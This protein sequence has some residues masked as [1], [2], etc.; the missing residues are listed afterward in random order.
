MG[1]CSTCYGNSDPNE[2]DTT[3]K[4]TSKLKAETGFPGAQK[5]YGGIQSLCPKFIRRRKLL[6]WVSQQ[7]GSLCQWRPRDQ[8]RRIQ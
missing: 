8:Q 5:G 2:V 6:R 3:Q 1:N 4:V 7:W